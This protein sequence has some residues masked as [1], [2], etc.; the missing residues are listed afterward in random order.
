MI[1]EIIKLRGDGLSFR[2]IALELNTTVGKVQYRWNKWMDHSDEINSNVQKPTGKKSTNSQI[3]PDQI[4]LKGELKAK[5]VSP[6]KI[7]LFWEVS[8]L[9]KKIIELFF[10]K[11][12]EEL[13]TVIRVY[14][15]TDITFNGKNANHFYE[16]PASY[17]SGHWI[18]KGLIPNRDYV[19]ELG[20]YFSDHNFFPI[21]RS[22]C[23]QTPNSQIPSGYEGNSDLYLKVQEYEEKP[24]KWTEHVSTYSYYIE[25][26]TNLEEKNE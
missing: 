9:P 13:V 21:H 16:I 14:D 1:D 7:I 11:R 18:I 8:E 24:P 26:T 3:A 2:R 10:K 25:T 17:Q 5:L 20:I 6:R 23:I 15:V 22:N 19:A 12:F 4:P